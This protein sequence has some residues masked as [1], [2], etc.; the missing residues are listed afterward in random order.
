MDWQIVL[1]SLAVALAGA[2]LL[3]RG[4]RMW[5]GS[6]T[7]CS[8]GCGC[9]KTDVKKPAIIAPEELVLRKR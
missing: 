8:G 5:R 7:G 9:A 4:W 6:K 1:T 3:W 2:F